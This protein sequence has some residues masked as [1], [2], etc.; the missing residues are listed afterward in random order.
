M[1][2]W[3]CLNF[4]GTFL[5]AINWQPV[6]C[7]SIRNIFSVW[8]FAFL[9]TTVRRLESKV[10][11]E[12]K[13]MKVAVYTCITNGYDTILAPKFINK[14]VD[15]LCFNDGSIRV[16]AG[17]S[18]I[19]LSDQYSDRDANRYIKILPHL[20]ADLSEY[21]LT[22]YVDGSIGVVGDLTKLIQEVSESSGEIFL[23]EH[24]RRSCVYQE[25]RACIEGMKAPILATSQLLNKFRKEGIPKNSGLFEGGVIV[26]KKSNAVNSLMLAWWDAYLSSVKRDQLALV[27]AIFKS[28][29]AV[30]SLGLPDH[31]ITQEY[32][33]CREGHKGDF[34]RRHF[35]WWV[36]R[37]V[38]GALIDL[39]LINL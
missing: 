8:Y 13:K 1:G 3:R 19:K 9:A 32:F 2:M 36:W 6:S 33:M 17:W 7:C 35:A 11:L 12:I 30:Q 29:I 21:D 31:R 14:G 15:Y 24:P 10:R 20:N 34:F 28:R 5:Q 18:N 38:V 16:P 37:P 4:F 39:R 25:A 22:I 26:R 23:Y 27:Y